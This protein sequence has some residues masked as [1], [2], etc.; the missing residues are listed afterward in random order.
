M[1][2]KERDSE[3]ESP[4][5]SDLRPEIKRETERGGVALAGLCC[6]PE[7]FLRARQ[8]PRFCGDF[9]AVLLHLLAE[10]SRTESDCRF[11]PELVAVPAEC[12]CAAC[13]NVLSLF[14]FFSFFFS[15]FTHSNFSSVALLFAYVGFFSVFVSW[16]LL[17]RFACVFYVQISVK[18]IRNFFMFFVYLFKH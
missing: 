15:L 5:S 18:W 10:L 7:P 16:I 8:N 9:V 12:C 14:L 4:E 11:V 2:V 3:R 13:R 17:H 1:P 6:G